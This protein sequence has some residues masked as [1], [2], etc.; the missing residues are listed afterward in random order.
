[1]DDNA[2]RRVSF[3]RSSLVFAALAAGLPLA[4]CQSGPTGEMATIEA[5]QGSSEN[6]ESLTAVINRSPKEA[7]GY[8]VRVSAYGRAGRYREALQDFDQAVQ[9]NSSFYQAYSNR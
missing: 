5:A 1:M 8:N 7:E 6:I 2:S 4:A 3:W 9:L